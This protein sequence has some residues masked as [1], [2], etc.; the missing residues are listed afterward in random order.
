MFAREADQKENVLV[1][2][3][4]NDGPEAGIATASGVLVLFQSEYRDKQS[5]Q[6]DPYLLVPISEPLLSRFLVRI[7]GATRDKLIPFLDRI[8]ISPG[9]FGLQIDDKVF[10]PAWEAFWDESFQYSSEII[11]TM[12]LFSENTATIKIDDETMELTDCL[13]VVWTK[14][15]NGI[16][17]EEFD[18]IR[19]RVLSIQVSEEDS[20]GPTDPGFELPF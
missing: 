14:Q 11:R 15:G 17:Q 4:W 5:D 10:I 18:R 19:A 7:L 16:T 1:L 3:D 6:D 13:S 9:F 20:P 2:G 12:G 8:T